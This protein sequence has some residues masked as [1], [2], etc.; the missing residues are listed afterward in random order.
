MPKQ[1]IKLVILDP[2][3]FHAS[4][5]Q[6]NMMPRVDPLV[7]VYAPAGPDVEDYLARVEAFN[8]RA[9]NP[10]QWQT[11]LYTGADYLE[12]CTAERAGNVVAISGNNL[13]KARYIRETLAAGFNVL[14]DKPMAINAADFDS[15]ASAF[16]QA[17]QKGLLLY[18]IMT[19]R[20]EITTMLQR[21]FSAFEPVFGTLEHGSPENP[22]VVKESVHHFCKVVAGTPLK[23]PAWFF[24]TTQYGEGIVDITTH[25]VDLVQWACF[26]GQVLD[27]RRDVQVQGARRWPTTLTPAQFEQVTRLP[28]YPD[29]LRKDLTGDTLQVYANGEIDYALK[30]VH[31]KVRVLWNFEAPPGTGD[32]HYSLMRG[33][34]AELV[35]RQGA[36][37]NYQPVLY[38]ESKARDAA[39]EAGLQQALTALRAKYP[40][41]DF[42]SNGKGWEVLIPAAYHV[43]HEA[44][45]GQ[46]AEQFMGYLE[47][48]ALPDWEVP[49]M[50]AKYF[51]NTQALKLAQGA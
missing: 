43:G 23:R 19:E 33:S 18:D 39:Y 49:G 27:Y 40:G 8:T 32:T 3:H 15:L 9:G 14:A 46:V 35:I 41:I 2:G 26:P 4:L 29:Y 25:L 47:A 36:E 1:T 51:T 10:T 37:Q 16:V 17:K 13:H 22:A 45:F 28:T 30:G 11:K 6:K 7:H 50:L 12:R 38:I 48:G 34:R 42:K 31:A 44:H 24:D 21:E 20:H 5:L